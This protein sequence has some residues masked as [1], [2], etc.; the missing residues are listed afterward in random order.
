MADGEG[1]HSPSSRINSSTDARYSSTSRARSSASNAGRRTSPYDSAFRASFSARS[2]A[3]TSFSPATSASC[4]AAVA[5]DGCVRC[6][7]RRHE[8]MLPSQHFRCIRNRRSR[9]LTSQAVPRCLDFCEMFSCQHQ[10]LFGCHESS[11]RP[12][13]LPRQVLAASLSAARRAAGSEPP[14][15][16]SPSPSRRSTSSRQDCA[17]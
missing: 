17:R 14:P 13:R 3:E 15:D 5:F 6:V 12:E 4:S 2:S 7:L 11:L 16:R 10:M 1:R 9:D 8:S